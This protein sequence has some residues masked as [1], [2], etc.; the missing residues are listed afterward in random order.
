[1]MGC[2][3]EFLSGKSLAQLI[4]EGLAKQQPG[5]DFKAPNG[6]FAAASPYLTSVVGMARGKELSRQIMTSASPNLAHRRF[7]VPTVKQR[8]LTCV[9]LDVAGLQLPPSLTIGY[10]GWG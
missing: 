9:P 1:M 10:V 6:P 5:T 8:C 2:N 3:R 7:F 4:P